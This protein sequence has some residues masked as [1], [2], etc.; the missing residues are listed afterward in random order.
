MGYSYNFKDLKFDFSD[1]RITLVD[2]FYA[3]KFFKSKEVK[4]RFRKA[5]NR[6]GTGPYNHMM[7][8]FGIIMAT[9]LLSDTQSYRICIPNAKNLLDIPTRS[10]LEWMMSLM[11]D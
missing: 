8:I 1:G 5:Y 3:F 11:C 10:R 6:Y 7:R 4:D 2:K 9:E